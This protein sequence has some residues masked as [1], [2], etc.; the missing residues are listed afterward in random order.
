MISL[1]MA[2]TLLAACESATTATFETCE[3]DVALEPVVAAPGDSIT[4]F[5]GPFLRDDDIDGDP[6]RDILVIVDGVG[7]EVLDVS[8]VDASDTDVSEDC[9][10][11]FACREEAGC[12]PCGLCDGRELEG[13]RRRECFGTD[14]VIAKPES[15]ACD[16]CE[17]RVVFEVPDVESGPRSVVLQNRFGTSVPVPLDVTLASK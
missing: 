4:V 1:G 2:L 13:A 5:G 12:A 16:R 10:T 9:N 11:C 8:S 7:A 6:A 14:P 17:Q 15:G 3:L